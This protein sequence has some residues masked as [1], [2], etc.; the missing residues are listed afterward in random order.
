MQVEPIDV[1][2][3]V[4]IIMV[5]APVLVL[6]LGLTARFALKPAVEALN[7]FLEAKGRDEAVHILERRMA[8]L[9]QQ[10]EILETESH[11]LRET[12]AFDEQLSAGAGEREAGAESAPGGSPPAETGG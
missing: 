7:S 12:A 8:L 3:V 6:V 1:T 11:R 9:E 4:G 10:V 2:A 5:F